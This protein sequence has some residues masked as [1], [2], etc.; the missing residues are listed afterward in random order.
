[1]LL[2]FLFRIKSSNELNFMIKNN[3][4]RKLFPLGTKLPLIDT[5]EDTLKVLD[6]TKCSF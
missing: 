6:T 4:F 1:V 2:G 5:I 3:E